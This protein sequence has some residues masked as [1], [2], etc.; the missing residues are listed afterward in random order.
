MQLD[1]ASKE[2]PKKY[3]FNIML[4]TTRQQQPLQ[5]RYLRR[6]KD[7]GLISKPRPKSLLCSTSLRANFKTYLNKTNYY[8]DN[9]DRN[10]LEKDGIKPKSPFYTNR[11]PLTTP[12][13]QTLPLLKPTPAKLHTPTKTN[14]QSQQEA[15]PK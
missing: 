11:C 10:H 4:C 9:K 1:T 5:L 15:V 2:L 6:S 12:C 8:Y 13:Q 14:K 3:K 7:T